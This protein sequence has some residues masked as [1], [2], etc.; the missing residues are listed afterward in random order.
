[1][2]KFCSADDVWH[3]RLA[4]APTKHNVLCQGKSSLEVIMEHEDFSGTQSRLSFDEVEAELNTESPLAGNEAATRSGG[5]GVSL[6]VVREPSPKYVLILESSSSMIEQNLW[7]WVHKSAQKFIRYDLVDKSRLAIVTFSE[8]SKVQHPL[9]TLSDERSRARMADT[10]PDKYKVQRSPNQRCVV[11]GFQ[12][13]MQKVLSGEEAGA[14]LILVTRGDNY[15]LS[16]TDEN[17]ILEHVRKFQIKFSAILLPQGEQSALSFYDSV[18]QISG[19]RTVVLA[20]PPTGDGSMI[21]TGLY[22]KIMDAFHDIRRLDSPFPADVPITVHTQ[23]T[24]R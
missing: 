7:K 16:L 1:M 22:S 21:S 4:L 11:C 24:T 12:T 23:T 19:G 18:S 2:D 5:P 8:E 17:L 13:A 20:T 10:I 15:T 14:H 6:R 3:R 9:A